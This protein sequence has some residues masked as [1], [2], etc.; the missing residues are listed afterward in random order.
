MSV[1]GFVSGK[2]T[3]YGLLLTLILSVSSFS[4]W[5]QNHQSDSVNHHQRL[6]FFATA[7]K[8][9]PVRITGLSSA[10]VLSYSAAM[11]GLNKAWYAQYPRSAFHFFNDN[12]EWNQIDK[13]GHSWT[14]YSESLY[15]IKLYRWSG[16]SEKK[17]VWIGGTCGFVF[18]MGIEVLD[19]F[20]EKWGASS[21][22]I[23][24]NTAGSAFVISQE[25][26]WKEQKVRLKFSSSQVSY[27]HYPPE[28]QER[29]EQLYG[30]SF[31]EKLLKDYNGQSYWLSFSP[32]LFSPNRETRF[33]DW[34]NI[35]IGYG[36]DGLLGGFE[37][38]W[39]DEDGNTH[40]FSHISRKRTYYLSADINL[41]RIKTRSKLLKT[42]FEAVNVLKIP[43]PAISLSNSGDFKAYWLYW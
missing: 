40:D 41:S 5:A 26:I 13:I 39:T 10:I 17:A 32:L 25:L 7:P 2:Q 24:A 37:N 33:P 21:G 18:Q 38:K 42:I 4:G 3:G 15:A 43:A 20:S 34:L 9:N 36:A 29:I 19:G 6:P 27:R 16:V 22:D 8:P 35:A 11:I 1:F 14:A 12:G 23:I 28:V 31:R 30:N